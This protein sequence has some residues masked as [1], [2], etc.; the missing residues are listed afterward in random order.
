MGCSFMGSI[1]I[2]FVFW[3]PLCNF[4]IHFV[5]FCFHFRIMPSIFNFW[6]PFLSVQHTSLGNPFCLFSI[7]FCCFRSPFCFLGIYFIFGNPF[8]F[9]ASILFLGIHYAILASI[10]VWGSPLLQNQVGRS[11]SKSF[12]SLQKSNEE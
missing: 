4:G 11:L 7:P 1:R 5:F 2:H 6:I 9:L 3:H 8:C 12:N 10:L